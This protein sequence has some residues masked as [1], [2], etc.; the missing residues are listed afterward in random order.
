VRPE[1]PKGINEVAGGNTPVNQPR[2]NGPTLKGSREGGVATTHGAPARL[3][4]TL[5]ES[6]YLPAAVPGALPP[7]T[8]F[9]LCRARFSFRATPEILHS[10]VLDLR[11][12]L[13][14]RQEPEAERQRGHVD[15]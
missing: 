7:A 11:N 15:T 5:S 3:Y 4:T 12:Y 6:P 10:V 14:S 8:M 13:V 9:C 2:H 1:S